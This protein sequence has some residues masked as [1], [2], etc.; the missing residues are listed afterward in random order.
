MD[1]VNSAYPSPSSDRSLSSSFMHIYG[2]I[3]G[4]LFFLRTIYTR[5]TTFLGDLLFDHQ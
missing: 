4:S 1:I 3:Y 5:S 2:L